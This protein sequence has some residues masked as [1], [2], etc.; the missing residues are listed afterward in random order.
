MRD[1]DAKE[2]VREYQRTSSLDILYLGNNNLLKPKTYFTYVP[3]AVTYRNSVFCPQCIDVFCV[4]LRT[5]SDLFLYTAL[6]Y[7]S[8]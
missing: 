7:R 8:L 6:T 4:D 3:P 1:E 2:T 5:N